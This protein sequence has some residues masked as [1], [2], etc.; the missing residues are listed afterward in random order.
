M[1]TGSK[2]KQMKE[3]FDRCTFVVAKDDG[4]Q[5]VCRDRMFCHICQNCSKHCVE[6]FGMKKSVVE[7]SQNKKA[8]LS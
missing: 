5:A 6:H 8:I 2:E 7:L 1:Q 3:E 4:A